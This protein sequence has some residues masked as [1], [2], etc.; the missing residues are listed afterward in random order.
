MR[1]CHISRRP[2]NSL[3]WSRQVSP[4]LALSA[5]GHTEKFDLFL[6]ALHLLAAACSATRGGAPH[7][8]RSACACVTGCGAGTV[9]LRW[10]DDSRLGK[11]VRAPRKPLAEPTISGQCVA[12]MQVLGVDM[13]STG[14]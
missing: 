10:K 9:N 1:V 7:H 3:G 6:R 4:R 13:P 5:Y 14:A 11:E 8:H 2:S 12:G